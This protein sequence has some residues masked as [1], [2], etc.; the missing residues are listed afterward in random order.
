MLF[1]NLLLLMS[2][3]VIPFPTALLAHFLRAGSDQHVAA[4]V[5]SG[6]LLVMGMLFF[7]VWRWASVRHRLI[8]PEMP[9]AVV[10]YLTRRNLAGQGVYVGAFA[11]AFVSAPV[12]LAL[13]AVSALYYVWPGRAPA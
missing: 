9:D 10:R 2:V 5:Y 12:S 1:L 4:A 13:C 11:L 3:S 8:D 7:A 6:T